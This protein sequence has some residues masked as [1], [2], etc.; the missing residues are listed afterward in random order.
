MR[1]IA[2]AALI[3]FLFSTAFAFDVCEWS[4]NPT[5]WPIFDDYFIPM[6]FSSH[7]RLGLNNDGFIGMW[8]H[9]GRDEQGRQIIFDEQG[10]GIITRIWATS[11]N[12]AFLGRLQFFFDDEE[13]PR[14]DSMWDELFGCKL[15]PFV[16]PFCYD[17]TKSSG[18][19]ILIRPIPFEKR[20]VIKASG[21]IFFWH[22]TWRRGAYGEQVLSFTGQEDC[23]EL[24]GLLDPERQPE[25]LVESDFQDSDTA[26]VEPDQTVEIVSAEGSGMISWL[27]FDLNGLSKEA[28]DLIDLIM[29]FDDKQELRTEVPLLAA[30]GYL[31]PHNEVRTPGVGMSGGVGYL[32]FPMPFWK[33]FSISLRNRSSSTVEIVWWLEVS[34]ETLPAA[35]AGRFRI[36]ETITDPTKF[37]VDATLLKISGRGNYIGM[38]LDMTGINT[39][40]G[41]LEGD[42]HFHVD[43]MPDAVIVGTGTEDFFSG[44]WYFKY[45]N[46]ALPTH[47]NPVNET[48]EGRDR[49]VCYRHFYILPISFRDGIEATV[50]HDSY[51]LEGG[52][53]Y[54]AVAYLYHAQSP[55][56]AWREK[57]RL[58][59]ALSRL[60]FGYEFGQ[61]AEKSVLGLFEDEDFLHLHSYKGYKIFDWSKIKLPKAGKQFGVWVLRT[62]IS[63]PTSLVFSAGSFTD[64]PWYDRWTNPFKRLHQQPQILPNSSVSDDAEI[65]WLTTEDPYVDLE[66]ETAALRLANIDNISAIETKTEKI[67]LFLGE[68]MEFSDL[69]GTYIDGETE[70]VSFWADYMPADEFYL[71]AKYNKICALHMPA[72]TSLTITLGDAPEITVPVIIEERP[73]DDSQESES[74][75][76]GCS[77]Q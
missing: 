54:R 16:E 56:L 8:G 62:T 30:F 7:D 67:N 72:E 61:A 33:N 63:D 23:S 24:A 44:G 46:F 42:E 49:T 27:A 45:G 20:L 58:D 64:A 40:R 71:R 17:D 1:A 75:T 6:Q 37:W 41:Y 77:C 57:C 38:A 43:G 55:S 69:M 70:D 65:V 76:K 50:E 12:M 59:N 4:G 9:Y 10:P 14:I 39:T 29:V 66:I 21:N 34:D 53:R 32:A 3:L 68:C 11:V 19:W 47:G 18:G 28:L 25:P 36:V 2:G 15:E 51:N 5:N 48:I 74:E 13:T 73:P 22:V 35:R 26:T 52:D 60:K 31:Y